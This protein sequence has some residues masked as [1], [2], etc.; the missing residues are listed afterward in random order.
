MK[1]SQVSFFILKSWQFLYIYRHGNDETQHAFVYLKVMRN[2]PGD[3]R[4]WHRHRSKGSWTL[5]SADNGWAVSDTTG[6][7][8]KVISCLSCFLLLQC[9]RVKLPF[10][11]QT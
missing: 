5:S 7:A 11:S 9:R 6:E 8:L 10:F 1:N 4:Y 3:Q 2:H